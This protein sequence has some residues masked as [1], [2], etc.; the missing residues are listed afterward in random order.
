MATL[1]ANKN[2]QIPRGDTFA[3]VVRWRANGALVD[4]T[5]Y[6]ADLVVKDRDGTTVLS[7]SSTG[8]SPKITI[9]G[10]A[11]TITFDVDTS[12]VTPGEYLYDLQ[13]VY[14]SGRVRTL[15]AGLFEVLAD[16]TVVAGVDD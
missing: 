16:V 11:G 10:A 12:A 4:L 2:W 9:G 7:A 15:L 5:G 6:R 1:P 8:V 3:E 14:P 13:V